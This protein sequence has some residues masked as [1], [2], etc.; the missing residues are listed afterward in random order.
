MKDKLPYSKFWCSLPHQLTFK[1]SIRHQWIRAVLWRIPMEPKFCIQHL[2]SFWE[3]NEPK[4][5]TMEDQLHCQSHAVKL[6]FSS[7]CN[8]CLFITFFSV[9]EISLYCDVD[10]HT[11][12]LEKI[13]KAGMWMDCSMFL[14]YRLEA[15][16]HQI[17]SGNDW[18]LIHI[19]KIH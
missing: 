3:C 10:V 12:L 14:H 13:H 16:S 8:T 2:L 18:D 5:R 7:K 11:K 6:T 19:L 15:S 9:Y 4:N 1:L 17:L